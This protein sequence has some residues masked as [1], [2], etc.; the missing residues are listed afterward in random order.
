MYQLIFVL[1]L[2]IILLSAINPILQRR[3]LVNP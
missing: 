2:M 3:K 1:N